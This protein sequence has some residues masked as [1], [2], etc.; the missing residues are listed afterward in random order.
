M[1]LRRHRPLVGGVQHD[2]PRDRL[3]PA[4]R[5]GGPACARRPLR[6]RPAAAAVPPRRPRRRRL[7]RLGRH[8]RPLPRGGGA[9]RALAEPLRAADAR[10]RPAAPLP[11]DPRL[12]RLRPR[13]DLRAGPRRP[14]AAPRPP[15]AG[16]PA[17]ARQRDAVRRRGGV[18]VV[19]EGAA[20]GGA[21]APS[22]RAREAAARLRRS[23]VRAAQPCP[24]GRP[25][26]PERQDGDAGF[27]VARR[28]AR[29]RGDAPA[30]DEALLPQRAGAAART[31]RL[32][33]HRGAR[34]PQRRRA[35]RR[36][37]LSRL[38]GKEALLASSR[39]LPPST[40]A[41]GE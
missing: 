7:R 10:A 25:A 29:R 26:R 40:P 36:R 27:H 9:R 5:R 3:L 13:H 23:R 14:A 31:R 38:P 1:A 41:Q 30:D 8:G 18:A 4:V 33:R 37:R 11:D 21:S 35:D 6:Q 12:R 32:Q 22:P 24:R 2:R 20:G 34:R 15:G 39:P 16:R 17:R 28:R 19:A